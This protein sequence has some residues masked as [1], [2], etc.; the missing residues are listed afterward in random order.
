MADLVT[1][2]PVGLFCAA[3][4]FHVDPWGAAETAVITHVH[5]DHLHFG[6]RRYICTEPSLP[7][8]RRRL[9]ADVEAVGIPYGERRELGGTLV[10][11]HPAGHVL[12]SAQIRIEAGGEVWVVSGDY[13]RRPDSTCAPF[14]P[15][16]CDVFITEAT[17]G[18]PIYRWDEPRLLVAD[19]HAWWERNREAG[20]ASV[21]LC[22]A[23]GK[24]QRILA[25]LTA[26]TD[27][28]V[29]AHGAVDGLAELYR[30]AG[31][32]LLPTR[33]VADTEKGRSFA[34]ELVLAPPSAAGSTWMRRF[35]PRYE[36][37]FASGWMRVRGTR[38]RKGFDRGF[39]LSDHADWPDLLRTI[40]ET[41]ARRVLVTHG[42]ADELARYLCERGLEAGALATQF[43]GEGDAE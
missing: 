40:E 10:S 14:E 34:G 13:K 27:R 37:G 24:A 35:A 41:G 7:F 29:L 6:S 21:L 3:G 8:L 38:R 18:L 12:G 26:F 16:P 31:V 11:F 17:F 30:Q 15:V 19:I 9:G 25:E 36:T 28:E 20:V 33:R 42:Y 39:A 32:K 1:S 5:G 23:M 4:G 43:E 22:Y 2:T